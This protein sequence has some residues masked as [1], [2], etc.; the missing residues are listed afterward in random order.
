M[1]QE[2]YPGDEACLGFTRP[3]V[4]RSI[5]AGAASLPWTGPGPRQASDPGCC[6]GSDAPT[7]GAMAAS[8]AASQMWGKDRRVSARDDRGQLQGDQEG[9]GRGSCLPG[10]RRDSRLRC[11]MQQK[12]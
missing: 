4:L 3:L 1:E 10:A 8:T 12:S 9:L 6:S 11:D 2:S 7:L 5:G